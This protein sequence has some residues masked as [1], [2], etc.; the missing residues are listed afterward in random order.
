[1]VENMAMHNGKTVLHDVIN[2]CAYIYVYMCAYI[3]IH[4]IHTYICI[5]IYT[6]IYVLPIVS[7]VESQ[8][9]TFIRGGS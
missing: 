5:Y 9:A 7:Q 2:L 8:L 3:Y 6:Y 1:M 4:N